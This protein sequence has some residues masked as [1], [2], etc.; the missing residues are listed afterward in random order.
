MAEIAC[1]INGQ[2]IGSEDVLLLAM[3]FQLEQQQ[4]TCS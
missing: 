4:L 3:D 1:F 2:P